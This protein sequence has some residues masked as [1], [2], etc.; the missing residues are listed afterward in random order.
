M[1]GPG[2]LRWFTA[3]SA[4]RP[5]I[6]QKISWRGR[7]FEELGSR[8]QGPGWSSRPQWDTVKIRSLILAWGIIEESCGQ[9]RLNLWH[10]KLQ[11]ET[12]NKMKTVWGK[13][14]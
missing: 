14:T 3:W 4:G 6:L 13:L 9:G 7:G 1:Q 2:L 8:D 12:K 10:G 11:M 5:N